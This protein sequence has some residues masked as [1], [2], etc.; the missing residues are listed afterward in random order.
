MTCMGVGGGAL[1]ALLAACYPETLVQVGRLHH[2]DACKRRWPRCSV[3]FSDRG[4]SV[5]PCIRKHI[6][7]GPGNRLTAA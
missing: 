3:S 4:I 7:P 6:C 5:L 1:P 2:V